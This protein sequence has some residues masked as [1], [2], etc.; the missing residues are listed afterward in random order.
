M[1]LN[2][3]STAIHGRL[4]RAVIDIAILAILNH[5]Q[6]VQLP[7]GPGSLSKTYAEELRFFNNLF[8]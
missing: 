6:S 5:F 3:F 2:A 7:T 1:Q 8:K 4:P